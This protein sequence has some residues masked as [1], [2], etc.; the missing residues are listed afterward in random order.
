MARQPKKCLEL[1]STGRKHNAGAE[2]DSYVE[3]GSTRTTTDWWSM[4]RHQCGAR[5]EHGSTVKRFGGA[6]LDT[7]VEQGW[8][9]LVEHGSTPMWSKAGARLDSETWSEA[10]HSG[11]LR[12]AHLRKRGSERGSADSSTNA[13]AARGWQEADKIVNREDVGEVINRYHI[14]GW[15]S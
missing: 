6:W 2:L 3:Q 12:L 14:G 9:K 10:R 5:L 11:S 8:S 13:S 7:N 4:A 15:I 1:S